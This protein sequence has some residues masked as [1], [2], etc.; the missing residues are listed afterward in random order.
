MPQL[1]S[2]AV[3]LNRPLWLLPSSFAGRNKSC[4][5][6][7]SRAAPKRESLRRVFVWKS[8][9]ED[10]EFALNIQPVEIPSA[11]ALIAEE[12]GR[13]QMETEFP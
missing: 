10:N 6:C 3:K 2:D 5:K 1:F 8:W 11:G 7:A 9:E 13:A 4:G 12:R